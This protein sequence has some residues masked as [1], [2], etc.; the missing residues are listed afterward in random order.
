MSF[1]EIVCREFVGHATDCLD[2][3][4]PACDLELAEPRRR[5]SNAS[6]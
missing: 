3:A 5:T 6:A 1:D 4:L 2:G